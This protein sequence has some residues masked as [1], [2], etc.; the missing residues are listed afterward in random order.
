[1]TVEKENLPEPT[2]RSKTVAETQRAPLDRA[3]QVFGIEREF[4]DGPP[5]TN[6]C[7]VIDDYYELAKNDPRHSVIVTFMDMDSLNHAIPLARCLVVRDPKTGAYGLLGLSPD[8]YTR[9][10]PSKYMT[11]NMLVEKKDPEK[12]VR[13]IEPI[14]YGV[15]NADGSIEGDLP[16]ELQAFIAN[17]RDRRGISSEHFY[18]GDELNIPNTKHIENK[19]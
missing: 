13:T 19:P 10:D 2:R 16:K 12:P 6:A 14:F 3:R 11:T 17:T 15:L 18:L 7:G 4:S 8:L 5:I 9:F 1:M